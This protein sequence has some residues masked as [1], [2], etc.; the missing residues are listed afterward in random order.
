MVLATHSD[1]DFGVTTFRI[2]VE[3]LKRYKCI[4]LLI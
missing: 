4:E 2:S 1:N 3:I